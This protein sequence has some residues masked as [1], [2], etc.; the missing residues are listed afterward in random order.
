MLRKCASIVL[1]AQHELLGDLAVRAPGGHEGRDLALAVGE[2]AERFSCRRARAADAVAEP[3]QLADRFVAAADGAEPVERGLRSRQ[4]GQRPGRSPA[5]ASARPSSRRVRAA[6]S[7]APAMASRASAAATAASYRALGEQDR[8]ARM[9]DG[10]GGPPRARPVGGSLDRRQHRA[11]GS[12]VAGGE[13]RLHE[14]R[15][16]VRAVG[17]DHQGQAGTAERIEHQR[18]RPLR[19]AGRGQR[20]AEDPRRLAGTMDAQPAPRSRAPPLPLA[21]RP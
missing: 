21:A 18:R 1:R 10:R 8:R 15:S 3:A 12:R 5:S 17:R 9:P 2:R 19:V 6:A 20:S 14:V 7:G 16:G 11:C 13:Q 4:G